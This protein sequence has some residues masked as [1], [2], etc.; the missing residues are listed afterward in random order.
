MAYK[1]IAQTINSYTELLTVAELY[2]LH[3]GNKFYY[4]R[5]RLQR[6]LNEWIGYKKS[7][8]LTS[9]L[10]GG[11]LKDL[12]QIAKI[13]PIVA[14]LETQL[15]PTEKNY[16]F[17]KENL[18]YFKGLAAQGYEYLVLDGQHR[19]DTIAKYV[20]SKIDFTPLSVIELRDEEQAGSI[21]VK[22]V[23]GKMPTEAQDFF[24][25][26]HVVVTTYTTGDLRELAQI[27]IT[28][29]DMEPMTSHERRIL[30]YNP[31]NRWLNGLFLHDI[32][33]RNMFETI[34]GMSG[35]YDIKHKGDTLFGAEMLRY[36]NK[37]DY[38]GYNHADLDDMLGSYPKKQINITEH[39]K[40]LTAQIFRLIADGCDKYDQKK[41]KKFTKSSIYNLFY[42]A[43]FL[44]RKSTR[45]NSSHTDISRMPS[46]A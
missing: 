15:V 11:N 2:R 33:I 20:E 9:L 42:T 21:Y 41:L 6:L 45:L 5:E 46:S 43:S 18:E 28:S 30:N 19:I 24:M 36:I 12:F 34:A 23:F 31:L 38:D 25:S 7:S 13:E 35:E 4:D 40:K 3:A 22:G 17:I 26:Q 10:N 37:N 29:N 39:D 14:F 8:Y 27:F 1:N 32:A 44:D 16:E